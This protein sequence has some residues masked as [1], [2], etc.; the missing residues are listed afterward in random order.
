[1]LT[2]PTGNSTVVEFSPTV[3]LQESITPFWPSVSP[4][5]TGSSKT[6]GE[7]HGERKDTSP[8]PPETPVPSVPSLSQSTFENNKFDLL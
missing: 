1:V 2:L 3:L 6:L 8:L 4:Q 5:E 7:L